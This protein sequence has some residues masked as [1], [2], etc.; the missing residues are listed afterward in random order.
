MHRFSPSDA[1]LLCATRV[2]ADNVCGVQESMKQKLFY[3]GLVRWDAGDGEAP[4]LTRFM[5]R[6]AYD[7]AVRERIRAHLHAAE[8]GQWQA[9]RP[10]SSRGLLDMRPLQASSAVPRAQDLQSAHAPTAS[11][12]F[13]NGSTTVRSRP[14]H[15]IMH[16]E[17]PTLHMLYAQV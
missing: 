1:M 5:L 10:C 8:G 9:G 15:R 4:A 17:M 6:P 2:C 13:G 14:G 16:H 3:C 12:L 11:V 7:A